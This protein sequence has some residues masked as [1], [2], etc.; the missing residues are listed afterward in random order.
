MSAVKLQNYPTDF[1]IAIAKQCDLLS[2]DFLEMSIFGIAVLKGVGE[3]PTAKQQ[4]KIDETTDQYERLASFQRISVLVDWE[5]AAKVFVDETL[6]ED[7]K[8]ALQLIAELTPLWV[9]GKVADKL[10]TA[11]NDTKVIQKDIAILA[12]TLLNALNTGEFPKELG[13]KNKKPTKTTKQFWM[14]MT[15]E[16]GAPKNA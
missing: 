14:G 12:E 4:K 16:E 6:T 13:D 3:N 8:K 15:M 1:A 11:L 2:P 5:K 9:K 7:Q 10:L